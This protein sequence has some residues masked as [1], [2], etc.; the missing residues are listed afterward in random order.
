MKVDQGNEC[1]CKHVR[2]II[3]LT[4]VKVSIGERMKKKRMKVVIN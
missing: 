4:K 3:K 2:A 1:R